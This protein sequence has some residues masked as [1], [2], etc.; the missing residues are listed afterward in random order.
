MAGRA[1]SAVRRKLSEHRD[2]AT[3]LF[4]EKDW[5]VLVR[6]PLSSVESGPTP[7][8]LD[9]ATW[10]DEANFFAQLVFLF[11]RAC[12]F[13]QHWD[14]APERSRHPARASSLI[15]KQSDPSVLPQRVPQPLAFLQ[16]SVLQ[17]RTSSR[18]TWICVALVLPIRKQAV[19][20]AAVCAWEVQVFF[21][22]QRLLPAHVFSR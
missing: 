1:R 3:A 5:A 4:R 12:A 19:Q 7:R 2:V 6:I 15:E 8:G 21:R 10:M 18:A 13:P 9:L 16:A 14:S 17:E 20:K 11:S 22:G